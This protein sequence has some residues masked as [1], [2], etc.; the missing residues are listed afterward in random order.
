[1]TTIT[2]SKS[3]H[4]TMEHGLSILVWVFLLLLERSVAEPHEPT[5]LYAVQVHLLIIIF[6]IT[7]IE[8]KRI[9]SLCGL[10]ISTCYSFDSSIHSSV[11][12]VLT[13][14][15]SSSFFLR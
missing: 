1:M 15:L 2:A 8:V 12:K 9:V 10:G 11:Q 6:D 3:T 14:L 7:N 5:F 4:L 13:F